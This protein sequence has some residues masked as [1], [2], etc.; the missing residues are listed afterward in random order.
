[1]HAC[2]N[3]VLKIRGAR[4]SKNSF[5]RFQILSKIS[6]YCCKD[7]S[8]IIDCIYFENIQNIIGFI[9]FQISKSLYEIS[10]ELQPSL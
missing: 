7:F 6:R 10:V 3:R 5:M 9:R 1:M 2:N 8:K 4:N